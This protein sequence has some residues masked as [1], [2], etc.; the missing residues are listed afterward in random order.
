[1]DPDAR[2]DAVT[3]AFSYSGSAI[4]RELLAAGHGVRTLTGHAGRAPAGSGIDVRPLDFTDA[5]GLPQSPPGVP[6]LENHCLWP[7]ASRRVHPTND[8]A[9]NQMQFGSK[10]PTG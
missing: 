6:N 5:G 7:V 8:L 9:N 1:M 10:D 4:A 3:G 2:L